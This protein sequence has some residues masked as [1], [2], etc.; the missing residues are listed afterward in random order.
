M[1]GEDFAYFCWK[2]DYF[3]TNACATEGC[4]VCSM[5]WKRGIR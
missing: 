1:N 5:R 3:Y 4:L 2:R